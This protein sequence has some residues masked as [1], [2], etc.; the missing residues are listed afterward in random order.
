M[1][2]EILHNAQVLW[3]YHNIRQPL[4]KADLMLV[5]CSID[6]SVV[7]YSVEL[8]QN[9]WA[10]RVIYSGGVA[11]SDDLLGPGWE[12][13]EAEMFA[14]RAIE[15]GVDSGVIFL[16]KSAQNTGENIQNSYQLI[17]KEGLKHDKII[18]IQKPYMLRRT[19]ATF[20]KQWPEDPKPEFILT[21]EDVSLEGYLAREEDPEKIINIMVGDMQR[22]I[23]YPKKGFQVEQE[24]SDDVLIAYEKLIEL[25][26]NKHL[27][28]D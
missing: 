19:L 7:D 26:F 10:T 28:K 18:L 22:I 20:L 13:P 4:S 23:E 24:M 8:L 3:N 25:G 17:Q 11:H 21:S 1:N 9:G 15:L 2:R 16:E 27:I 5:L 12:K 14:D 6:L